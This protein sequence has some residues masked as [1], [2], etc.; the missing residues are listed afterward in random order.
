MKHQIHIYYKIWNEKKQNWCRPRST[1]SLALRFI[2]S[3]YSRSKKSPKKSHFLS[4]EKIQI[5]YYCNS[6][7]SKNERNVNVSHIGNDQKV[8]ENCSA[9]EW[10]Y[11]WN[12]CIDYWQF[13]E[14][15]FVAKPGTTTHTEP[16]LLTLF[17]NDSCW[18][19]TNDTQNVN[20]MA[21][22]GRN[23]DLEVLTKKISLKK[24]L[25][26]N[27]SFVTHWTKIENCVQKYIFCI[28]QPH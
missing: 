8:L 3:Y 9:R 4:F 7:V 1:A 19:I 14:Q 2:H 28:H 5:T 18:K 23:I 16:N 13:V 17:R 26:Q 6:N 10:W 24:H 12:W 11:G 21:K 25:W 22:A 15:L 20:F 27:L